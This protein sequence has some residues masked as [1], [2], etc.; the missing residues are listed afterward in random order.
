MR[1][2]VSAEVDEQM[3]NGVHVNPLLRTMYG[4]ADQAPPH[5]AHCSGRVSFH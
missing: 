2:R 3:D 5:C 4:E 1:A